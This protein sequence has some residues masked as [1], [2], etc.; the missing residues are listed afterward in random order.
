MARANELID[1]ERSTVLVGNPQWR[2]DAAG[3]CG[4]V[5]GVTILRGDC[6]TL[7]GTIGSSS[8]KHVYLRQAELCNQLANS[9]DG[10]LGLGLPQGFDLGI[11]VLSL[12]KKFFVA[13][14]IGFHFRSLDDTAAR[15]MASTFSIIREVP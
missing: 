12:C 11:E 5:F 1:L 15:L 3:P 4:A 2:L 9:T 6:R 13:R 10:L 8:G 7:A 14:H